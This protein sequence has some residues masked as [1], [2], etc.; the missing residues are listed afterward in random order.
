MMIRISGNI[1]LSRIQPSPSLEIHPF[2]RASTYAAGSPTTVVRIA[3]RLATL[4]LLK[5]AW[6][7]PF[8]SSKA[9]RKFSSVGECGMIPGCSSTSSR[10][11]LNATESIQSSGN[12][13]KS[14]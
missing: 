10:G 13:R 11:P 6:S 4:K 3:V 2:W 5:A 8:W 9:S 1:W 12:E 7:R 14:M